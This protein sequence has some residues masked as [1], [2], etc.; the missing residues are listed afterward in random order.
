MAMTKVKLFQNV[1]TVTPGISLGIDFPLEKE[2]NTFLGA[3]ANIKLIDVKLACSAAPVG[4]R[5]AHYGLCALV[6]YEEG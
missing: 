4:D 5:V 3:N 1:L 6:I 2:I